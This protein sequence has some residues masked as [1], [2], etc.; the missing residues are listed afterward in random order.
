MDPQQQQAG[1][2][3]PIIAP[4]GTVGDVPATRAHDAIAAGGKLGIDLL[5]PDGKLGTV[6]AD[7]VHDAIR[8]GAQLAPPKLTVGAPSST[9]VRP[10]GYEATP[11]EQTTEGNAAAIARRQQE[12]PIIT[13]AGHVA[14]GAGKSAAQTLAPGPN[15]ARAIQN[16]TGANV[17]TTISPELQTHG[18]AENVG[19]GLEGVGEFILG[20]EAL[21]GLSLAERAGLLTKVAKLAESHPI[22]ARALGVGM[23][24]IRTGTVGGIQ[25]LAH[26]ESLPEA[27][28]TGAV[29][30][31]TGA[32]LETAVEGVKAI[33]PTVKEIAG[34][35]IPVRGSQDSR[36]AGIAEKGAPVGKLQ[37]FDVENT[38]PA[39]KEA[40][41]NISTD[42]KNAA[43][44]RTPARATDAA[45][46]LRS[47]ATKS[48]NLAE[49]AD[50]IREQSKP[51]FEKLDELTKD[52][53]MTF[54]ELQQQERGAYRRGD[55]KAAK[56]AR[57]AQEGILNDFQDQFEP[58]EFQTAR[59]NWRQAS[60]LDDV[61]DTLNSK[62]VVQPTPVKL[63]PVGKPDPGIINGKNFAK[64][65]LQLTGEGTL[66]KAGLTPEHIQNLQDLG[67]LL[68]KSSVKEP[69]LLL[70][71]AKL[72]GPVP[73]V[74]HMA[75]PVLGQIMTNPKAASVVLTVAKELAKVGTAASAQSL[76][77]ILQ[78][79]KPAL[80][81]DQQ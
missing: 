53:E 48:K 20:D 64:E 35:K 73:V 32:A 2:T 26:G 8:A 60:A 24:A 47:A 79:A 61:H 59:D 54:S 6:P 21:K 75:S 50:S 23:N 42:V 68:E 19:A 3:I 51:V 62:S 41:S 9:S 16:A 52:R 45:T 39:S 27:A 38:Q 14:I 17:P 43:I 11:D 66:Q 30:G 46:Q 76:R 40:L 74:S 65:I 33:T 63:R 80:S 10:D 31:G 22:I 70:K 57:A 28:T 81:N 37:Q 69:D 49:A 34:A 7:R 25:G 78:G 77:A 4:D 56:E 36:V 1:Q 55:V 67:T 13:A 18:T 12:N 29:A 58:K 72:L 15:T 71:A 44:E 5:S